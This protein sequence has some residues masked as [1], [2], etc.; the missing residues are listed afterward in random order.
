MT[1]SFDAMMTAT[2]THK[3]NPTGAAWVQVSTSI[4]ITP[5]DPVGVDTR[6]DYPMEKLFKL[7]QC[8]TEYTAFAPGDKLISGSATYIVKMSLSYAALDGMGT[9]YHV[10]VEEDLAG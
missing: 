3:N 2:A 10:I 1:A 5:L 8:F 7:R 6:I 9:Y 4:P